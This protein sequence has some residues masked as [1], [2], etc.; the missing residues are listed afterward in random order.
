MPF[1]I[2]GPGSFTVDLSLRY[3]QPLAGRLESLDFYFDVF[4]V[5]NRLNP[6]APT[7]NRQSGNFMVSTSANFPLQS[8]LGI[9]L[10]F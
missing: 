2:R 4:N 6:I 3:Q 9:R 1:G 5:F 10:R 8:Q 7:G